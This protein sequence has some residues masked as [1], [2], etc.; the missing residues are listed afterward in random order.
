MKTD[1]PFGAS[2]GRFGSFARA[3]LQACRR[4]PC[5]LLLT[6][7]LHPH[8]LPNKPGM[9]SCHASLMPPATCALRADR[10]VSLM[11]VTYHPSALT[12]VKKL[13]SPLPPLCRQKK[14]HFAE[15]ASHGCMW[16]CM[17]LPP[18]AT[19]FNMCRHEWWWW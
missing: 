6:P 15:R 5:L 2:R 3:C 7:S 14:E 10:R 8:C 13:A 12:L 18:P 9:S 16:P 17:C 19:A 4:L 1:I 11:C